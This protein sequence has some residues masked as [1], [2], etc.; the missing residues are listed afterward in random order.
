LKT[1]R[2]PE[3]LR[4]NTG[5]EARHPRFARFASAW[6]QARKDHTKP[7]PEWAFLSDRVEKRAGAEWKRGRARKAKKVIG[8]LGKMIVKPVAREVETSS[9]PSRSPQNQGPAPE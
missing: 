9:K 1:E 7:N 2:L 5:P 4:G 3:F 6:L 8:L